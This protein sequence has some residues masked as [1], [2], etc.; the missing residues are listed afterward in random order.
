MRFGSY[1]FERIHNDSLPKRSARATKLYNFSYLCIT[2]HSMAP[3]NMK[4]LIPM[5]STVNSSKLSHV[6]SFNCY[7]VIEI[8]YDFLVITSMQ[9]NDWNQIYLQCRKTN[10]SLAHL[11]LNA[12]IVVE[13]YTSLEIYEQNL[14]RCI[15]SQDYEIAES[16][17]IVISMWL[18]AM[19][20]LFYTYIVFDIFVA[21]IQHLCGTS[22]R[23]IF[24]L[25]FI[26]FNMCKL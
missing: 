13:I 6:E 10:I 21:Q 12:Q 22:F 4:K 16:I 1:L 14:I 2:Q 23:V 9:I 18:I 20:K 3:L 5:D 17:L 24:V 7:F 11:L 25:C 8:C 26:Y 15:W 19:A